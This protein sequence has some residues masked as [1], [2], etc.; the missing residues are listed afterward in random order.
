MESC[1]KFPN[2]KKMWPFVLWI[3]ELV[4]TV[5][6]G[7]GAWGRRAVAERAVAKRRFSGREMMEEIDEVDDEEEW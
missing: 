1:G 3:K 7:A 5:D 6:T 2:R 4:L